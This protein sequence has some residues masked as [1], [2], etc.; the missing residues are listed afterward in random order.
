MHVDVGIQFH[1]WSVC[2]N[3]LSFGPTRRP[4]SVP[5]LGLR[6]PSGYNQRLVVLH[7]C[8]T[9]STGARSA[10]KFTHPR[11]SSPSM[12]QYVDLDRSTAKASHPLLVLQYVVLEWFNQIGSLVH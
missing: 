12:L 8:M 2:A 5:D 11:D 9:N 7:Y 3:S 4:R 1:A 6:S 10:M